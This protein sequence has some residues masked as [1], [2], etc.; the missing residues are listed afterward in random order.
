VRVGLNAG[1]PIAEDDPD[2][3]SDLYGTA[4][5]LA[6]RIAA[7]AEGG[8]I[9]ASDAARQLVKG[10]DFLFADRGEVSLKGFDEPRLHISGELAGGVEGLRAAPPSVWGKAPQAAGRLPD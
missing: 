6:A 3:R 1:E 10:K 5:N 8:E 7:Q 2:G 4:V 9:L